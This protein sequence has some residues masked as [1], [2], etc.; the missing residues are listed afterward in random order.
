MDARL[1]ILGRSRGYT[2]ARV[3]DELQKRG[4]KTSPEEISNMKNG[5]RT[6]PKSD[7]VLAEADK[8]I[9]KWEEERNGEAV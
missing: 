4:I 9:S 5:R 2:Y 3:V 7:L 1:A 8:I 6:G